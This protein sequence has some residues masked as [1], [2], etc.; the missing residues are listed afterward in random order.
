MVR[1]WMGA[2]AAVMLSSW[3]IAQDG[4]PVVDE[5]MDAEP[6]EVFEDGAT[7]PDSWPIPQPVDFVCPFKGDIDY[8]PGEI[9]CGFITVPENRERVDSRMIRLHYVKLSAT[10]EEA[11]IRP[12]PVIY[13]TGG[14]G[15]GV[16]GYVA[17]FQNHALIEQRD[18]YILEQR[19]I[20][21]SG[22]FCPYFGQSERSL[23]H[24]DDVE[25][26]QRNSAET[27]RNCFEAAQNAGVDLTAYNTVENAR[28][29]RALRQALGYESWN[30]WG[31]S[32]GSHLGQML[33]QVDPDGIDALVID[34]IVPNDLT[35]L[36]RIGRWA[37]LVLENVLSECGDN[38]HCDDLE[39]RLD[40]ALEARRGN[41]VIVE[42]DDSELFPGGSMR[43][44]AE[45]LLFAP[46][47]MA[48]EQSE[49]PAIPAVMDAFIGFYETGDQA[50]FDLI[51]GG[52]PGGGGF[53][54]SQGMSSAI[55]CN[56]GYTQKSAEVTAEDLAENPR[57]ADL[58]FTPEGAAYE[59][60]V[61]DEMGLSPRDRADYGFIETDIPTLVVNGGWDPVTPPPLAEYIAPGFSNG[62]LIIVPYAGH[63]PT[64]SMSECAGPVLN[65]F[66]DN[67]DP[68]ALDATCLE[69]GVGAP[70]FLAMTATRGPLMLAS[71]ALDDPAS[72]ARPGL[73]AGVPLIILALGFVL[74]PIGALARLVDGQP[75]A[76]IKAD[77]TAPRWLGFLAA[78]AGLGFAGLTGLGLYAASE[79]SMLAAIVG[80]HPDG[81]L[82]PWLALATGVLGALT[83]LTLIQRRLSDGSVRFGSL[84]G[85][86][87]VGVSGVAL[88]AFALTYD[89]TVF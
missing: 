21:A 68:A 16:G 26:A 79:V 31:I 56:D 6:V 29:V 10:G 12:D 61:C 2:A 40:A 53:S 43:V 74:I 1:V 66:F 59:A 9:S 28:D 32:Y 44:G 75:A 7:L 57:F 18:L 48:Y 51:A 81:A 8:E 25:Q 72:L 19:G 20:G 71:A 58:L 60:S 77:L 17:R 89:L 23:V 22:D 11:D 35:D 86:F 24:A 69:E 50:F 70:E 85:L 38:P 15:A 65:A 73:W 33:T 41:P 82:A 34:A 45:A 5:A 78:I 55:R 84:T 27:M 80:L 42:T 47:M 49:H 13:L 62:R 37:N 88:A 67:P 63:G 54:F 14:P 46:F 64:R 52:P 30:V 76:E 3:A 39:A 36:M 4:E 83:L 87:F